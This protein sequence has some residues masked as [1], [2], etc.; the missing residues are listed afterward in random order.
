VEE[1]DDDD[2]DDD[3]DAVVAPPAKKIEAKKSAPPVEEKKR[4][5]DSG[6]AAASSHSSKKCVASTSSTTT[7]KRVRA[8][9][10]VRACLLLSP[11]IHDGR[12]FV[13]HKR[14]SPAALSTPTLDQQQH[15]H[16][17]YRRL[18]QSDVS[19]VLTLER[20]QIGPS[21]L[22]NSERKQT[23]TSS[24]FTHPLQT[25]ETAPCTTFVAAAGTRKKRRRKKRKR[26]R[27]KRRSETTTA[28]TTKTATLLR[29]SLAQRTSKQRHSLH[30]VTPLLFHK[31]FFFLSLLSC[32]SNTCF[33]PFT[34]HALLCTM[35]AVCR[36]VH[37]RL[38]NWPHATNLSCTPI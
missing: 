23:L 8:T 10:H 31:L 7:C 37:A 36:T 15:H 16:F 26:K 13:L 20:G 24:P 22:S 18:V 29:P 12:A 3:D 21:E 25:R 17:F 19:I 32:T 9:P 5:A 38:S 1:D 34:L 2:D 11:T 14:F 4:K 30:Q 33:H 35:R 27:R 28:M 6:A